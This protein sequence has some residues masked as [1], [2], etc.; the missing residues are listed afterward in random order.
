MVP[1]NAFTMTQLRADIDSA[2]DDMWAYLSGLTEEQLTGLRDGEG[3]TVKDHLTHLVAWEQSVMAL[4]QGQPR[5]VG[6]GIEEALYAA[7]SF[8]PINAAIQQ[9]RKDIPL[10]AAMAQLRSAHADL[11]RR[12]DPLSDEELN[13]PAGE[14]FPEVSAGGTRSLARIVFDNTAEHFL[15]HLEWIR[16]LC[17]GAG[18]LA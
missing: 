10:E 9:Q 17:E 15:E 13:R 16:A 1:E 4:L 14:L 6:L 5:H 11:M 3:W 18:D 12:L 2:W 8:D 7:G